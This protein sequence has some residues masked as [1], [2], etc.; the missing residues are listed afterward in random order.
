[1]I[2]ELL[3]EATAE[4][5]KTTRKTRDAERIEIHLYDEQ[6]SFDETGRRKMEK[7]EREIDCFKR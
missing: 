3:L 1:M 7:V 6:L 4:Y 5:G 2:A